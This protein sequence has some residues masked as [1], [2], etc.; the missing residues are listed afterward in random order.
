MDLNLFS[1]VFLK[2]QIEEDNLA[3]IKFWDTLELPSW[4]DRLNIPLRNCWV[5]VA[6]C[7]NQLNEHSRTSC[8]SV[9][10]A[11]IGMKR[12]LHGLFQLVTQADLTEKCPSSLV[13]WKSSSSLSQTTICSVN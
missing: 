7:L 8:R 2:E 3:M 10:W 4:Q 5:G 13:I 1:W 11:K 9:N 6:W 12:T